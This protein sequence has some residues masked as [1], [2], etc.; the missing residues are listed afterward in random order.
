M[1]EQTPRSG[2]E[3]LCQAGAGAGT[4]PI[5]A[6]IDSIFLKLVVLILLATF[7]VSDVLD[8]IRSLD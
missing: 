2:S 8:G 3:G 5:Q 6:A 4:S 1:A 7:R